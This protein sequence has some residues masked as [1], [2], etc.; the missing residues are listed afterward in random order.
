MGKSLRAEVHRW[1]DAGR[2][3]VAPGRRVFVHDTGQTGFAT[4]VVLLHG[5]PGSSFDWAEVVSRL[6][7]SRRVVSLDLPGYGFSDKSPSATYTLFDQATVVAAVLAER[8]IDR[9][10][11]VAHNMGDTVAA[12][13]LRR[14]NTDEPS[15]DVEQVI[16][17]NG[18]I[19]IDMAQLT[20]GQRL[21]LALPARALPLSLPAVVLRR[22]LA[23]SFTTA[24]P[25]PPGALDTMASLIKQGGGDRL[26]PR[27]IS[28]IDERRTHQHRWTAAL[29]DYP[30]ALSLV[31]G[32]EDPI[33]VL[34]M[35]RRLAELRPGTRVVTLPGVGHWPAVEAPEQ[36]TQSII[37][38]LD[39]H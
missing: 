23:E 12:E 9:C 31:W 5:F 29:V 39:S 34:P 24:C 16:L 20:R 30:G 26:L 18:S 17:T 10:V 6:A 32:E 2:F 37:R 3:T 7:V 11:L 38:I 14:R 8:G 33:S 36:L 27:L 4:P 25:P 15:V 21:L 28:Y 22:S 1:R 35:T 19:F 13:L